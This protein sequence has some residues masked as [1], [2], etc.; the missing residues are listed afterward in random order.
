MKRLVAEIRLQTFPGN[1]NSELVSTAAG[2]CRERGSAAAFSAE[3]SHKSL[4]HNEIPPYY[5]T[6][7]TTIQ[8]NSTNHLLSRVYVNKFT[9][10]SFGKKLCNEFLSA[11]LP[12]SVITM[13][14]ST[15]DLC[16]EKVE[17]AP[18]ASK[19]VSF[20]EFVQK[21]GTV[22]ATTSENHFCSFLSGWSRQPSIRQT[23][24]DSSAITF[25]TEIGTTLSSVL[26][27]TPCD[28]GICMTVD[29]KSWRNLEKSVGNFGEIC[30]KSWRNLEEIRLQE[31]CNLW[32]LQM[33]S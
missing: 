11:P 33:C 21:L 15:T 17:W 30:R 13:F 20:F 24:N 10:A 12:V 19:Y 16:F 28:R 3:I 8:H 5:T 14:V 18:K 31:I 4:F 9:V 25:M 7:H 1:E 29:L 6:Y 32:P 2:L 27:H 22:V 23:V 26:S